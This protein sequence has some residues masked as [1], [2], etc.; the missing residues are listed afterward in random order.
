M[1]DRNQALLCKL[2]WRF[3]REKDALWRKVLVARYGVEDIGEGPGG[4]C[5]KIQ[6]S[7]N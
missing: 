4:K 5:G 3:G 2:S 6:I 1:E 7:T